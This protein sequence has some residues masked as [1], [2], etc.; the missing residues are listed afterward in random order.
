MSYPIES[1]TMTHNATTMKSFIKKFLNR[2]ELFSDNISL[3]SRIFLI[4]DH[5]KVPR[6]L[7]RSKATIKNKFISGRS[8]RAKFNNACAKSF[9]RQ[10]FLFLE[11]FITP[12]AV[13][14][15]INQRP[16]YLPEGYFNTTLLRSYQRGKSIPS[17]VLEEIFDVSLLK[18]FSQSE[19]QN[20][21]PYFLT[22]PYIVLTRV[23]SGSSGLPECFHVDHPYQARITI[24]LN[25][26]DSSCPHMQ[27]LP[28]S[29]KIANC[30]ISNLRIKKL[31]GLRGSVI[32][33]NGNVFH[34]LKL[35]NQCMERLTL[36]LSFGFMSLSDLEM[37]HEKRNCNQFP[38]A[39]PTKSDVM[40]Q[41][42]Q[43]IS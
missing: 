28:G 42:Y 6:F 35:G 43:Y 13:D 24:L 38:T 18:I 1:C 14:R 8:S 26:I 11:D 5:L 31:T 29:H 16:E 21:Q 4:S 32:A 15:F 27:V 30:L 2:K 19:F 20:I 7:R 12:Q 33:H 37:Q 40:S 39:H 25:D 36:N 10:G 22:H 9:D 3:I 34:R 41:L 23:L 17:D